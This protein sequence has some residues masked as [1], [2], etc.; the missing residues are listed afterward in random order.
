MPPRRL[1]LAFVLLWWTLGVVLCYLSVRTVL[2]A[3]GAGSRDV[4]VALLGAIEAAAALLFLVPRTLR[5]G[6]AGLL[7]TFAVA[8]A[9]HALQGELRSDLL[10]FAAAVAFVAVH[11]PVSRAQL[12]GAG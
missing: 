3:A 7:A 6:A 8:F 12:R 4:H 1:V 9:A 10:V 5:L 2:H 11:G